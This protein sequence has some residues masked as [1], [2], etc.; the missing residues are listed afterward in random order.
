VP[1][2]RATAA[3]L[4]VPAFLSPV[5]RSARAAGDAVSALRSSSL[6]DVGHAWA[7]NAALPGVSL[8]AGWE[9]AENVPWRPAAH[10]PASITAA[11]AQSIACYRAGVMSMD[12]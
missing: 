5:R 2:R 3:A 10:D 1:A 6:A 9:G 8:R 4:G 11:L 7:A 12:V